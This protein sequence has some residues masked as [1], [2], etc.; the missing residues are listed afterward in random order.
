MGP[1]PT[2]AGSKTCQRHSQ[3]AGFTDIQKSYGVLEIFYQDF[4]KP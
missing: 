2:Q 1:N 4:L 3:N